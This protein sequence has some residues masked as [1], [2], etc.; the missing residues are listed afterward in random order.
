M[1]KADYDTKISEIENKVSDHNHDKYITT[2]KFNILASRVFNARQKQKQKTKQKPQSLNKKI[3]SN[4]TKHL[5]VENEKKKL[6][7]FDAAYFRGKNYFDDDGMQN[8]L[9]FQTIYKY[10]QRVGN[11]VS[12]WISKG[13]SNEKIS[14]VSNF[15]GTAPKIVYDNARIKGKI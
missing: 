7:N 4:K 14:S 13:L 1:K 15:N 6:N 8:Y 2:P 5:P 9:V 12:S 10:F 3:N 11:E